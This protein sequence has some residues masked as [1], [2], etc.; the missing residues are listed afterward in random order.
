MT[1]TDHTKTDYAIV[2]P[3]EVEDSS[4]PVPASGDGNG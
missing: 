1:A 4:E 2:D 3:D